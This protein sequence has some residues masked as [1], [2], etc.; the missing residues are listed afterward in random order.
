MVF[1]SKPKGLPK[2]LIKDKQM[3]AADINTHTHTLIKRKTNIKPDS[4]IQTDFVYLS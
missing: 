2:K 4:Q 3:R 1:F